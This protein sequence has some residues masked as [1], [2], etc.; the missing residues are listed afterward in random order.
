MF[1]TGIENSVSLADDARKRDV[2]CFDWEFA[3]IVFRYIKQQQIFPIVDLCHFGL[4]DWIGNFQNPDFPRP[5]G[6]AYKQ[7]MKEWSKVLLTRSV[8]LHM[9]IAGTGD[10]LMTRHSNIN[11]RK[12][13]TINKIRTCCYRHQKK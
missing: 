2:D 3:N 11:R 12:N 5:V 13:K 10:H 1:A 4:P 9:P 6:E 7:L 8:C